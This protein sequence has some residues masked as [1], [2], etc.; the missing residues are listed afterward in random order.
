MNRRGLVATSII[1]VILLMGAFGIGLATSGEGSIDNPIASL[2]VLMEKGV[3]EVPL[4]PDG[5]FLVYD[6]GEVL[7]LSAHAQHVPGTENV[8]FCPSSQLFES[9]LHGEKFDIRGNYFGGPAAKGLDRFPVRVDGDAIYVDIE[10]PI[11]GP[12]RG[13]GGPPRDPAGNF[14]VPGV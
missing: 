4:P 1:L 13:E 9:P 7:A 8:V 10:H 12:E 11:P 3:L 2:E 6:Q 5:G 14:C